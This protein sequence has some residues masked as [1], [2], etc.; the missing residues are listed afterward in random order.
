M[1][2]TTPLTITESLIASC[3]IFFVIYIVIQKMILGDD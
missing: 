2:F 3:S 1:D